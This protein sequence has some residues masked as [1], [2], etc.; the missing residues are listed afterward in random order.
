MAICSV[1]G[2]LV[3]FVAIW[4][5]LRLFGTF[6]PRL[7]MLH[8]EKSGNP[9]EKRTKFRHLVH[10]SA[11][12]YVAPKKS[13]NAAEKRTKFR[14]GFNLSSTSRDLKGQHS[15]GETATIGRH[16]RIKDYSNP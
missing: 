16:G 13:G 9:A 8:E 10:F 14:G 6:F 15:S 1:C 5:I 12:W 11:L 4:Y 7:G 2:Y 3:H